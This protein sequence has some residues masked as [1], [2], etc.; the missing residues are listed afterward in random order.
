MKKVKETNNMVKQV[1]LDIPVD[2]Y[3]GILSKP[4]GILN[5]NTITELKSKV[6]NLDPK[7]TIGAIPTAASLGKTL[8]KHKKEAACVAVATT[9]V[10]LAVD[11]MKKSGILPKFSKE[12]KKYIGAIRGGCMDHKTIN[13]LYRLVKKLREDENYG[14]Y[15]L[16]LQLWELDDLINKFHEYTKKLADVNSVIISNELVEG[17]GDCIYQLEELLLMQKR[18][19]QEVN[20]RFY[21]NNKR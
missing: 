18:I 16:T 11:R 21:F 7:G 19:M 20:D 2:M 5:S 3:Q 1:K 4:E 14:D 6:P 8:K 13:S 17:D 10:V 12:L 9:I 15:F